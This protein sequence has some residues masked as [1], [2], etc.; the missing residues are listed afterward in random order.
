MIYTLVPRRNVFKDDINYGKLKGKPDE[1]ANYENTAFSKMGYIEYLSSKELIDTVS[2]DHEGLT[3]EPTAENKAILQEWADTNGWELHQ[4]PISKA[5]YTTKDIPLPTR[6]FR[7]YA[8]MIQ[9][10]HPWK[11][12]DPS[13]PDLERSLR[14]EK[15]ETVGWALVG[16]GTQFKY[17]VY[18][19]KQFPYIHQNIVHLN[20][21]VSYQ[22]L[23]V[24][25]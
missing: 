4:L 18:F 11:V 16:S 7:F 5:F 8:N 17:Q 1:L 12:N 23:P 20:L 2:Q 15:D 13:N 21:G 24:K 25:T 10:D 6:V 19:N 9:I 22:R 3:G 14:F